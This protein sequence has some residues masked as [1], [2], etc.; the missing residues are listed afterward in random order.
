MHWNTSNCNLN[1]VNFV[2]CNPKKTC[3]HYVWCTCQ[4]EWAMCECSLKSQRITFGVVTQASF[5]FFF[6]SWDFPLA[7]SSQ[8]KYSELASLRVPGSV[9]LPSP[10]WHQPLQP[11][12]LSIIGSGGRTEVAMISWQMLYEQSSLPI[13]LLALI[14]IKWY[15][16][17]E[18]W[19]EM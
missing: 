9:L 14:I 10:R 15:G 17:Q 1:R 19:E 2:T 7:L 4:Y 5:T 11:S 3:V 13:P 18:V 6:L 8:S 16:W 12:F